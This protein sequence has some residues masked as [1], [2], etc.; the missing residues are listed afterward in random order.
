MYWLNDFLQLL[1]VGRMSTFHKI[2]TLL[3]S[4][5]KQYFLK[6]VFPRSETKFQNVNILTQVMCKAPTP[7]DGLSEIEPSFGQQC[8]KRT[9]ITYFTLFQFLSDHRVH[10]KD[11]IALVLLFQL[12]DQAYHVDEHYTN[13]WLWNLSASIN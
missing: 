8:H 6:V 2:V 5:I 13:S 1:R 12:K 9:V 4:L 10:C 3:K 7:G 11:L